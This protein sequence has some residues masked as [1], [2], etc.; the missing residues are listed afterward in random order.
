MFVLVVNHAGFSEASRKENIPVA[1][2]SRRIA[3]LEKQT[4]MRL[5]Q[6]STR[7]V[8][9]TR[10]GDILYNAASRGLD[11][12]KTGQ[13]EILDLNAKLQGTLRISIPGDLNFWWSLL[14]AFQNTYPKITLDIFTTERR[15]DLIADGIDVA[16]RIGALKSQTAVARKVGEYRHCLVASPKYIQTYGA[17]NTPEQLRSFPCGAWSNK[18]DEINWNL[19][20][21][22]YS[23]DPGVKVND[24]SHLLAL[25]L[26]GSIITELPPLLAEPHLQSGQLIQIL[27][28]WSFPILSLNLLYPSRKY[29]SPISRTYIDFA[30]EYCK[31]KKLFD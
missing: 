18:Y 19:A 30:L 31:Q 29:L 16:L 3:E 6:R 8:K 11:E 5:L 22:D 21:K 2:L 27:T 10:E 15:I 20:G 9:T 1:T 24:F 23:V 14:S 28:T 13:L 4:G 12:I 17:P 25:A 26:E 7:Q